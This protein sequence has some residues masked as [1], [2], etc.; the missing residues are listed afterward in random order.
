MKRKTPPKQTSPKIKSERKSNKT[1]S[2]FNFNGCLAHPTPSGYKFYKTTQQKTNNAIKL[3][4]P[5]F[6]LTAGQTNNNKQKVLN[7]FK[8]AG[9]KNKVRVIFTQNPLEKATRMK[10][11]N[12][13]CNRPI[14]YYNNL[15][16]T[17]LSAKLIK[18]S[19]IKYPFTFHHVIHE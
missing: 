3:N 5:T 10:N 6:V 4:H 12:P 1:I 11:I 9:Y 16:A 18:R 7:F 8:N 15:K 17:N 14:N 13:N 2:Y 19:M